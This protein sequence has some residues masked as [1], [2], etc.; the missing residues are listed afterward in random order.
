M[1]GW[2]KQMNLHRRQKVWR[3]TRKVCDPEA[4]RIMCYKKKMCVI[5][6]RIDV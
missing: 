1:Y 3:K 2:Q 6:I 5:D 4:K